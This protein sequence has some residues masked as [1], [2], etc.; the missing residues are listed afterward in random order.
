MAMTAAEVLKMV[1]DNE[2]KFVDFRF[3]D[4]RGKEQHVTVPV[5]HFDMDKFES[6]HAL[7]VPLSL[8][9]KVSNHP[10]CC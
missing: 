9:G 4:T 7:T 8:A 5:S 6:G 10:T 3:A 1:K 2:V